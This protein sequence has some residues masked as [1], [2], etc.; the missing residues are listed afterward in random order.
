MRV[1]LAKVKDS[2]EHISEPNM[3][4]IDAELDFPCAFEEHIDHID[5]IGTNHKMSIQ[6]LLH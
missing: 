2:C 6:R 4:P 5:G 1:V 3:L